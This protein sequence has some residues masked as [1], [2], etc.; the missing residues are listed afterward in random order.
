MNIL[1]GVTGSVA[2][3]KLPELIRALRERDPSANIRVVTTAHARWFI[4]MDEINVDEIFTDETEWSAWTRKGDPVLHIDLRKWVDVFLVAPLSANSLAKIANG[5]CDNLLTSVIRAWDIDKRL[6][7]CPAM[8]TFMWTNP[9]TDRHLDVV[10]DVYRAEVVIPK[11]EY[12]LACG[13]VGPG[14]MASVATVVD[15]VYYKN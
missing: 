11:E 6:I 15:S 8:N 1:I 9:F 12:A 10:R 13:D 4:N 7:L 2:T 14:A 3:I 5:M